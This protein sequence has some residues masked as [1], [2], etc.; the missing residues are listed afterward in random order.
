MLDEDE[1]GTIIVSM[2]SHEE[3]EYMIGHIKNLIEEKASKLIIGRRN[4]LL[5]GKSDA[6]YIEIQNALLNYDLSAHE[7]LL[8]PFWK[9]FTE[10]DGDKNGILT[11]EEFR[12]LCKKIGISEDVDRL[13]DQVDPNAT[14]YINFSDCVNLFT[15][16]MSQGEDSTQTSVLHALFFQSQ[17]ANS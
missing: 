5:S 11:E 7:A 15:Y 9:E 14:G 17:K 16:E 13:L 10:N 6:T 8:E 12:N 3:A 4:K 2:F 1:W